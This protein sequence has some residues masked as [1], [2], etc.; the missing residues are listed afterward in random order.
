[1]LRSNKWLLLVGLGAGLLAGEGVLRLA[2]PQ[3]YRRPPVWEFD[4]QLGWRH[5]PGARGQLVSPEFSVEYRINGEGLRDRELAAAPALG[6]QR[7]LCFG[8]S[9]VEGWGV[10]QEERVSEGLQR[11]LAGVEVVNFGVAGYGTDQEWLL[12]EQQ[13]RHYR[14]DW[15]VV[16]FYGNDLWNNA[17]RQGIGAERGFKPFFQVDPAGRLQLQGVPVQ[18]TAF[19]EEGAVPGPWRLGAYLQQHLHIW[20]VVRKGLAPEIPVQQQQRYYQGLYGAGEEG[21]EQWALTGRLL[22][23]F[24]RSAEGAGARL[25]LVYVPALLQVEEE[26]WKMKRELHGLAGEYD[27]HK[28][29]R[30]LQRLAQTNDIPFLD[31]HPAFALE[32]RSRT[33]YF[34]DSHWNPA[35]HELASQALAEW[36]GANAGLAGW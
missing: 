9:F 31:L 23:A 22:D 17:A 10:G 21:A 26:D 15:V 35:G 8:D 20:A 25:L 13:G 3:V 12:F 34:R 7:L 5:I 16:F 4:P 14:P 27:L 19:W 28:P 1:M 30:Q 33:L 11:R 18:K 6:V 36:F 29:Q 24:A 2:A 32:G